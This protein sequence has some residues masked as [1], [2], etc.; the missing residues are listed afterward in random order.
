MSGNPVA[1]P[2]DPTG[3]H[4][5]GFHTLPTGPP[6]SPIERP[7]CQRCQSRTDL[8]GIALGPAG[9]E[10]RTFECPRCEQFQRT[11]VVSD[12]MSGDARGWLR[13]QLKSTELDFGNLPE[14]TNVRSNRPL[15]TPGSIESPM[16]ALHGRYRGAADHAFGTWARAL[17]A[18]LQ[19]LR[20]R[21]SNAGCIWSVAI[22]TARLV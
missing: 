11:L 1:H 9:Y 19:K 12:P 2:P 16:P 14:I 17:D 20:P 8:A 6:L 13:G 15:T 22:R 4:M 21:P 7:R 10:L 5:P 18:A 3:C